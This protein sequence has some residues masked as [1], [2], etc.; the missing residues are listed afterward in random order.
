MIISSPRIET[1]R[2]KLCN[3][4]EVCDRRSSWM[5]NPRWFASRRIFVRG[6][7]GWEA[8]RADFA[9]GLSLLLDERHVFGLVSVRPHHAFRS[10]KI[11]RLSGRSPRS[12]DSWLPRV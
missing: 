5:E 9:S 6:L 12:A 4:C 11:A 2:Y 3:R 8:N 10:T 1:I 7:R